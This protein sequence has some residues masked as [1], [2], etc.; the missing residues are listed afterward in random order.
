MKADLARHLTQVGYLPLKAQ[1]RAVRA[2]ATKSLGVFG[3]ASTEALLFHMSSLTGKHERELLSNYKEF[4]K[5]LWSV[6]GNGADILLKMFSDNLAR[7]VD[8]DGLG[9]AE[10]I[11]SIR[12]DELYVFVRNIS[13]GENVLLLYRSENFRD[14]IMSGFFSPIDDVDAR[15]AALAVGTLPAHVSAMTYEQL[16]EMY[17]GGSIEEK[18]SRWVS[19]FSHDSRH[20][21][22]ARDDTWIGEKGVG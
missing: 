3:E 14:R 21:R 16:Q 20:L 13:Y 19:S 7:N 17:K 11:D 18:V 12:R 5:A 22:L 6:L 8:A 10:I 4:E 2:A 1:E 15:S 9:M